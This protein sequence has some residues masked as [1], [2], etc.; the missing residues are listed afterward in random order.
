MNRPR[1]DQEEAVRHALVGPEHL[2]LYTRSPSFKYSIDTLARLLPPMI[3]GVAAASSA[4]DDDFAQRLLTE[5]NKPIDE[6]E[7]W[8]L[9]D[10]A[11]RDV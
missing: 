8:M 11:D 7:S 10:E 9:P 3:D 1:L 2:D 5:L 4:M 6:L